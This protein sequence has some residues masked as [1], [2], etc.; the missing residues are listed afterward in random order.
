MTVITKTE[1]RKKQI[2]ELLE[3]SG[4]LS[5][6]DIA[7]AFNISLPTV[8]RLSRSLA[9]EG[10]VLRTHGGIRHT[11]QIESQYSF[12]VKSQEYSEEKECIANYACSLVKPGQ[13]VFL[14]SGTTVQ[15]L[16]VS[17]A[18]RMRKG[19]LYD[20]IVFTNSLLNLEILHP[21]CKVTLLGGVYRPER[22]DMIGYLCERIIRGLRFDHAF[23]GA[24][25]I[26]LKDG[27]MALDIETVR[28]DELLVSRSEETSILVHSA[29]FQKHSLISYASFDE[30]TRIV[31]DTNL[32]EDTLNAYAWLGPKLVCI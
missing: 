32:P 17:L 13:T 15:Q 12:N 10:K 25:A 21:I 19:E 5:A 29:K 4:K 26:N 20:V 27:I 14:E 8:R 1:I 11:P 31:T 28:F 6:S 18:A 23:I 16:A 3:K 22:K 9:E 24:D 2:L 7:A 30:V